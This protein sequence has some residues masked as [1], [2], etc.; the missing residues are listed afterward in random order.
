MERKTTTDMQVMEPSEINLSKEFRRLAAVVEYPQ[1]AR[2]ALADI[3][4]SVLQLKLLSSF[5]RDFFVKYSDDFTIF[6]DEEDSVHNAICL[7]IDKVSELC[8][9]VFSESELKLY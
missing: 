3:S 8:H 6:A 4:Y 7:A 1:I 9:M 5:M 2:E